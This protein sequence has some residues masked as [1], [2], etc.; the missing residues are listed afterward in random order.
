MLIGLIMS[1]LAT[2]IKNP[3]SKAD[4]IVILN[5]IIEQAHNLQIQLVD[6]S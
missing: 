2:S 6:P 3:K 1:T 5:E 4:A